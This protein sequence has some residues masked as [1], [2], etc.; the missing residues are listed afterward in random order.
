M[1]ARKDVFLSIL[2]FVFNDFQVLYV[3]KLLSAYNGALFVIW[4][5]V[6]ICQWFVLFCLQLMITGHHACW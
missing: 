3:S 6:S 1:S 2:P 4:L 5:Y